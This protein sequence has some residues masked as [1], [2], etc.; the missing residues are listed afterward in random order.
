MDINKGAEIKDSTA[1]CHQVHA[2]AI[3]KIGSLFILA[4]SAYWKPSLKAWAWKKKNFKILMTY[5]SSMAICR[6]PPFFLY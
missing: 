4:A 5:C 2:Q 3:F 1:C 6:R